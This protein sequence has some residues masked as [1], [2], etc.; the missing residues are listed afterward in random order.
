VRVA[1][2][3]DDGLKRLAEYWFRANIMHDLLHSLRD[4]HDGD[5][6]AISKAHRWEFLTYMYYWLSALFVVVEGFNKLKLKDRQV[7]QLFK[8]H[9][10]DLKQLRHETYHFVVTK[11]PLLATI[12]S[13]SAL[14]NWAEELHDAIGTHIREYVERGKIKEQAE[15]FMEWRGRRKAQAET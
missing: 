12:S 1:S 9:V 10:N 4:M 8:E 6:E 5:L 13:I 7:Q 3:D 15:R 14:L 11:S 2:V